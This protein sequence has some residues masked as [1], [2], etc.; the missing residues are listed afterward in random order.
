MDSYDVAIVGAGVVGCAA[1]Y[2]LATD[3]DVLVVDRDQVA[4]STT[5]KA[6]GLVSPQVDVPDT[7]DAARYAVEAFRELDGTGHFS[8][9]E[10]PGVSLVNEAELAEEREMVVRTQDAGL[11]AELV[12]VE[13]AAERLPDAFDLSPF[14]AVGFYD[15]MGWVDPYTLATTLQAE[16]E[17][18]GATFRTGVTVEG[19]IG[20]D[21][22]TGI[23][24]T[25]GTIE[26]DHVVVA[27]GW[28]TRDLV[29][30]LVAVPVRPFRYQTATLD[31]DADVSDFPVAWEHDTRLYWRPEHNGDLHVGGQPYFVGDPGSVSTQ[32]L[33]SFR[34]SVAM[35]LPTYLP[36]L[37][38]ARVV[39][40]D[41]C[42][43]GDAASPDGVPILDAPAEAPDGLTVATGMHGF[44][45]MLA[46]VAGAAVRALVT[47]ESAPFDLDA[48]SLSRFE[49]RSADFGS[50]YIA[51]E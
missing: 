7:L 48:F 28:R 23:E 2:D 25:E 29:A 27:A 40:E 34:D 44:G 32:V 12:D 20:E 10:R 13:A 9:S 4:G 43:T 19:I 22:L 21:S 14:S 3:H 11:G 50:P 45:I 35:D 16:A 38:R 8:F 46:P 47:G 1:A 41:T 49:D 31:V 36:G 24:T 33:P 6:S 30:D 17:A 37:G 51:S 26:A 5:A 15:D 39:S 18:E 42:Q